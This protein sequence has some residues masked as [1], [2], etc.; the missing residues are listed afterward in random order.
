MNF[1]TRYAT[2]TSIDSLYFQFMPLRPFTIKNIVISPNLILAPM[3]GV[4]NSCFR[5][6]VKREN[7]HAVGLV[8]T[9]FIS[10]EAL[11]REN[12]Q[13]LRMMRF[14]EEERPIS[15]QIFGHEIQRMTDA[16]KMAVDAGA[17]IVDINCGCPVPKV[18]R[19]G[20]GCELMRQPAHL[21]TL[22][23]R[24]R[25]AIEPTPLS[26]KIRSGWDESSRNA[27]EIARI[28]E[29]AG[30]SALT[31]HGRTR[32]AL[33]RGKADWD[34]VAQVA[35]ALSIPVFGSGDVVS[36]E[37][38]KCALFSGV[39][40]I[41]IGR[42]A[43]AEPWIF[44]ELHSALSGIGIAYERPGAMETI[45][46]MERY[47]ALLLEELPERAVMG[48]MK[49]F[50]SQVTRRVHGSSSIRRALCMSKTLLEFRGILSM[51]SE[52][53][54]NSKAGP[55]ANGSGAADEVRARSALPM[56]MC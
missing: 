3:S 51:W 34:I 49:Q 2:S 55:S 54:A 21:G 5:R 43:L 25:R 31:V 28:A 53:L 10:V 56:E 40:A 35:R 30:V 27:L 18:V 38:A 19:K 44:S 41:M 12:E 23:E 8:V 16:A 22:L 46:V 15:I 13:S 17:D 36:A 14:H 32:S 1:V 9:E 29:S 6:L 47:L 11:T 39:S 52:L 33:Y 50:A 48:R 4:T 42:A 24:V 37:S 45:G 26:V 7:P 20:G